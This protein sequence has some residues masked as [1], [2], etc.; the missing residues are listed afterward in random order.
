MR[1]FSLFL[2]FA[3]LLLSAAIGYTYK[4]R[5]DK[6]RRTP[7][8]IAPEVRRG[9]EAVASSGWQ[10]GKDDPVTNKPMVR[11]YAKAFQATHDPSTFEL[12]GLSLKLY[13]KDASAYT[14]ISTDQAMFNEGS[15][16]LISDELVRIVMNVPTNEDATNKD[17]VSKH[18]QVET[19]GVS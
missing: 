8:Q 15:Q 16:K 1:R 14:Y 3:V 6:A 12:H 11:V 19:S 2:A 17:I 4:L 10:W 9:Y 7:G 13:N 18:V 5:L